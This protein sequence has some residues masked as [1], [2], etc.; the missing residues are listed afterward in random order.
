MNHGRRLFLTVT[1]TVLAAILAL[2][3]TPFP[4]AGGAA[5]GPGSAEGTVRDASGPLPGIQVRFYLGG[6][7]VGQDVTDAEGDFLVEQLPP[8]PYY[9]VEFYDPA[10]E[11]ATEWYFDRHPAY[12]PM[13]VPVTPDAT[14]SLVDTELEVGATITGRLTSAAGEP[15][16][17]GSVALW[18]MNGDNAMDA[19]ATDTT[20]AEGNYAV[21]RLKAGS[22]VVGF[23][24]P[25]TG[26]QEYWNNAPTVFAGSRIVLTSG[27][28]FTADAVLGGQITNTQ[29]PTVSGTPEVGKTLTASPGGWT[30]AGV[31]FAYRWVVGADTDPTDDPTSASYV[32]RP[33]DVGKTVRVHVTATATGWL[34]GTAT[35]APTA[36][37]AAAAV[38][39]PPATPAVV[40]VE[41][42]R[43]RG[44]ARVGRTLRVSSGEWEPA[45][46]TRSYQWYVG[47]RRV[48][49]GTTRRLFLKPAHLGKRVTVRVRATAPG[50]TPETIWARTTRV[51]R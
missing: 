13:F 14:N 27:T 10:G 23:Y 26:L 32:L 8:D 12:Q 28:S 11:Y 38:T 9:Y 40:N 33:A 24:D 50:H 29:A 22:Y 31:A 18:L 42:P 16:T 5:A 7:V 36:P 49:G 35:S 43:I 51:R 3:V 47:G 4:I 44:A 21:D 25:W 30:P 17:G 39:P 19:R 6:Q 37:V 45:A 2:I 41:R 1:T 20:D 46:V 48:R 34:T 15:I